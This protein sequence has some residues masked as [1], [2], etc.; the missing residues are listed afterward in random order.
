MFSPV[1]LFPPHRPSKQPVNGLAFQGEGRESVFH[2]W[3]VSP[4]GAIF[5]LVGVC[6]M[7]YFGQTVL[8]P[9]PAPV[10]ACELRVK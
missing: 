5:S 8:S 3:Q 7:S 2:A 1:C 4:R 9:H 10:I 6:I